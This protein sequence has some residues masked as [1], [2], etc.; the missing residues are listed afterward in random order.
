MDQA[1]INNNRPSGLHQVSARSYGEQYDVPAYQEPP[2]RYPAPP[3]EEY[4]QPPPYYGSVEV[5]GPTA[6]G[7]TTHPGIPPQVITAVPAT[8]QGRTVRAPVRNQYQEVHGMDLGPREAIP[9]TAIV[10]FDQFCDT[11]SCHVNCFTSKEDH[12]LASQLLLRKARREGWWMCWSLILLLIF[13]AKFVVIWIIIQLF[14]SID[15]VAL[16]A[17]AYTDANNGHRA[18]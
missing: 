18:I 2:P 8:R 7:Y 13:S 16:S 9:P 3:Y 14:L 17:V 6:S 12:S 11:C 10:T 4:S 15:L 5:T 1:P